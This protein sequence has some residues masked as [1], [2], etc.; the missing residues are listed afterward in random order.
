[1]VELVAPDTRFHRSFLSSHV[2]WEGAWQDGAGLAQG[3]L[4]ETA[5][6]FERW[7]AR[8]NAAE[9]TAP[10]EGMVTC[11]HRWIVDGDEYL[12]A[13]AFRHELTPFLLAQGGHIGYGVR[14]SARRRGLASWALGATLELARARGYDRVLIVCDVDNVASRRTIEGAGG[15]LEDVRDTADGKAMRRYWV[16]LA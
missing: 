6:G 14:P 15:V 16:P 9:T 10:G 3:D 2:E 11:T 13:I 8:L 5:Q 1:M 7:V 12:G 4:V